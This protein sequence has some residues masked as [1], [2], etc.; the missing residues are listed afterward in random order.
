MQYD[1]WKIMVW[2]TTRRGQML[3]S[4]T[5]LDMLDANDIS[6]YPAAAYVKYYILIWFSCDFK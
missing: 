1:I 3:L 2:K 6:H 4:T 5:Y